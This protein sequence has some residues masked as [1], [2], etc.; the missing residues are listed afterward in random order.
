MHVC[1][2]WC[3]ECGV[4]R[5]G[6]LCVSVQHQCYVLEY[7]V[8]LLQQLV[9]FHCSQLRPLRCSCDLLELADWVR[10]QHLMGLRCYYGNH[11][12]I[13]VNVAHLN[14]HNCNRTGACVKVA[15]PNHCSMHIVNVLLVRNSC[16]GPSL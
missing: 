13:L 14:E 3:L 2:V 7:L 12:N 11:Q 9:V 5:S 15:Q 4:W 16:K 1:L 10:K 8:G 6:C